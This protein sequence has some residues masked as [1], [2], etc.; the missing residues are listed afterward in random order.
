MRAVIF[1][2]LLLGLLG[3][4]STPMAALAQLPI[5]GIGTGPTLEL[6]PVSPEPF[7]SVSVR[8]SDYGTTLGGGAVRWFVNGVAVPDSDNQRQIIITAGES[9]QRQLV[10][11]RITPPSGTPVVLQQVFTPYYL[12]II[13]EPQTRV[14]AQYTA[15]ALPS[16]GSTV[17]ARAVLSAPF[18]PTG[19]TY[20][21][22]VNDAVLYAGPILGQQQAQFVM[23]PGDAVVSVTIMRR[24]E[25][26]ASKSVE[27]LASEPLLRFYTQNPL[28]GISRIPLSERLTMLGG[29]AIVRAEPFYLDNQTY[30]QPG[31]L[32]W[33]TSGGVRGTQNNN[34][35]DLTVELTTPGTVGFHVRNLTRLLQGVEGFITVE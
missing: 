32:E 18:D 6:S 20:S 16:E 4:G 19:L 8:L 34:P 27:L 7:T 10:E 15:R 17:L 9:G 30:N 31:L 12:D 14:P 26:L 25:V 13:I 21:W 24:G 28:Y 1:A 35:Y 29:S 2:S 23:P 33:T 22:R 11:A 3:L 5:G